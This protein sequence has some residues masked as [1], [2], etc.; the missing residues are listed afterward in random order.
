MITWSYAGTDYVFKNPV[1]GNEQSLNF[2]RV[3]RR[4]SGGDLT[5]F[6]D[7]DWPKIETLKLKFE[8]D[9][10]S[11]RHW[12]LHFI[13]STVGEEVTYRDHENRLWSGIIQN[14]NAEVIQTGRNVYSV[15]ILFE[16]ELV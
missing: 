11:D 6:R 9:Q 2:Q 10:E 12:F 3:N 16:G 14:P 13:R 4:T 1:L 5:I 7:G 8:F 15:E